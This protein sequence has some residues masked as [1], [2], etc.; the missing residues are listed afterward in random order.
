MAVTKYTYSRSST[1]NGKVN[2]GMLIQEINAALT[3]DVFSMSAEGDT[4]NIF[5]DDALSGPDQATLTSVI[6]SHA[7][8]VT[9]SK[10]QTVDS[11]G[12]DSTAETTYQT[13]LSVTSAK[14]KKGPYQIVWNVEMKIGN[15]SLGDGVFVSIEIDGTERAFSST[16]DVAY[17]HFGGAAILS[18]NEGDAPSVAIKYKI[19]GSGGDTAYIRR[20]RITL[21]ALPPE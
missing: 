8:D 11:W 21:F 5:M 16:P 1:A 12:E 13:K 6:G 18:F 2:P 17:H 3:T 14:L 15:G 9:T 7:G 19:A 10:T 4:L 20:A